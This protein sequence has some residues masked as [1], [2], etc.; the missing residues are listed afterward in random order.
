M[1][2]FE[3]RIRCLGKETDPEFAQLLKQLHEE[4]VAIE[5]LWEDQKNPDYNKKWWQD[6]EYDSER[7]DASN[8][9]GMV[10]YKAGEFSKAFDLFTESIRLCP[11]S[12]VYHCNRS[13]AALKLERPEIAAEDAENALERDNK[14]LKA[15][16]R[17]AKS[18]LDLRNPTKARK[19]FQDA[20]NIDPESVS[21]KN[22]IKKANILFDTLEKEDKEANR[23]AAAGQRE[24]LSRLNPQ[25]EDA[26]LRLL[27]IEQMLTKSKNNEALKCARVEALIS[28]TRYGDALIAVQSLRIGAERT[29]LEAEALWRDGQI[30]EARR[31][32]EE[33]IAL[34]KTTNIPVPKK[35]EDLLEFLDSIFE[36]LD[37]AEKSL[38]D[39]IHLDAIELCDQILEDLHSDTCRRFYCRILRLKCDALALRRDFATAKTMADEALVISPNDPE[40][41]RLRAD[42]HKQMGAYLDYFLDVQRLKSTSPGAAGLADLLEDAARLCLQH[43]ANTTEGSNAIGI[44]GSGPASSYDLL[45]VPRTS[46]LAEIRKA[47][48]SL[49][50]KVHPDKWVGATKAEQA[51]AEEKFKALQAA[52]ESLTL[53]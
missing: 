7:A 10:A 1:K 47:Y 4:T 38:E 33:Q 6:G 36:K 5:K 46:T 40:T 19:Y 53:Q 16:L 26:A 25:I 17:A 28:C 32:I 15:L 34:S 2:D 30:E 49:V 13:A 42:I 50:S 9:K 43:G 29:Y 21:A 22:G 11:T 14:Y 12:P 27:D 24:A 20:L 23:Y 37:L 3:W 51:E 45:G 39:G 18:Y 44:V 8:D 31:K 48:L 35:T 41:L 52:Y